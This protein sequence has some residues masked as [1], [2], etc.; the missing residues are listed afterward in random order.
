MSAQIARLVAQQREISWA[1]I[2]ASAV[3]SEIRLTPADVGQY[4][5]AN[6]AEFTDPEEIR[7]E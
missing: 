3:A 4:Y 7:A 5:A 6:K 1:D 2:P